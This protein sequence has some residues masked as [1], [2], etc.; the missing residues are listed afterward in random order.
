MS[1]LTLTLA[2]CLTLLPVASA[3]LAPRKPVSPLPREVRRALASGPAPLAPVSTVS[4]RESGT[5]S[6]FQVT[7]QTRVLLNGKPCRYADVPAHATIERM[8]VAQD[9]KT[10]L[11]IYF[12]SRK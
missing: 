9:K 4:T 7:D 1:R 11:T 10:V 3:S 12:R 8:E 6:A 5:R 2:T